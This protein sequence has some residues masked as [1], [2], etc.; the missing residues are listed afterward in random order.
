MKNSIKSK[1]AGSGQTAQ[2]NQPTAGLLSRAQVAKQLG[3][4]TH[5]I[6]RNKQL[7]SLKFNA[8]LV[9]YRAEDV[10]RL[11]QSAIV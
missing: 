8:R 3:V 4:C 2:I 9:R 11:I 5:T 6:A 7:K 10:A 1:P